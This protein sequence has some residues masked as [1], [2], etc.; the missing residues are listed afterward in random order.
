[1]RYTPDGGT[2][3]RAL[4]RCAPTAAASSRCATPASAS[5]RE[6]LPRLTE[7]FYRVDRSRSRETGGTG[8]GLAIV[9]HVA[10]RHGGE[11]G[12][13][14]E[15]GKGSTFRL[16]A[17]GGSGAAA[18]AGAQRAAVGDQRVAR[19]A[20]GARATVPAT[21]A[22]KHPGNLGNPLESPAASLAFC[23]VAGIGIVAV[24]A[25]VRWLPAAMPAQ[26]GSILREFKAIVRVQ[27]QLSLLISTLA[28]VSMFSVLTYIAYILR[29]VTGFTPDQASWALMLFSAGITVG[30]LAGGRLA[31]WRLMPALAGLFA[32]IA[33]VLAVFSWSSHHPL[34]ALAML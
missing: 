18:E 17:A 1:M 15:L 13:E 2:H 22:M 4:A 21:G 10:Q 30:G 12:I 9:K 19:R 25:L 23:A 7:R 20:R 6:H 34:P 33:G 32:C 11:L 29:D 3:R 27:V 5:P 16:V 26:Q 31:D 24:A 28:S 14:S 8:L